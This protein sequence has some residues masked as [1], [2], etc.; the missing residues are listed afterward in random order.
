MITLKVVI[1]FFMKYID[2]KIAP[3]MFEHYTV[4]DVNL[5]SFFDSLFKS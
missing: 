2:N 4:S 1:E 3:F 5:D